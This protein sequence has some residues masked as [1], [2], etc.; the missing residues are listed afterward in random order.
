MIKHVKGEADAD[1][2]RAVMAWIEESEANRDR[3]VEVMREI[4]LMASLTGAGLAGNEETERRL[5]AVKSGNRYRNAIVRFL[6]CS[7]IILCV[8]ALGLSVS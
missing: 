7:A 4:A 2:N 5:A 3:Y 8:L 1:E 6:S